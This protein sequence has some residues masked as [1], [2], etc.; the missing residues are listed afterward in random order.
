MPGSGLRPLGIT[1]A[2]TTKNKAPGGGGGEPQKYQVDCVNI[3]VCDARTSPRGKRA[4]AAAAAGGNIG[5]E[6]EIFQCVMFY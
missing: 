6:R 5:S 1:S 2:V 4:P 3:C